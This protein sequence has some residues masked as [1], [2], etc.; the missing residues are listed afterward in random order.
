MDTHTAVAYEG[1]K[2]YLAEIGDQTKTVIVSTASPYKFTK[3]VLKAIDNKY[4]DIDDFEAM[5]VLESLSGVN[6]P[7]PI[8]DIDKK[9]IRHKNVCPKDGLKDFVK[10]HLA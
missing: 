10:N 2:K 5:K 4:A 1:Y 7:A 3:D 9:E 6:I 8:K